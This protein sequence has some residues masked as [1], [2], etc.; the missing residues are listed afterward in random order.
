MCSQVVDGDYII[1]TEDGGV[2]CSVGDGCNDAAPEKIKAANARLIAAA[3]D[4]LAALKAM[5]DVADDD[6]VFDHDRNGCDNC[7]LCDAR[8]AAAKAEG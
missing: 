8:R 5:I 2:L 7:I 6:A 3:P 4:L 1:D